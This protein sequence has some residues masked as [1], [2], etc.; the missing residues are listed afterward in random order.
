M[1]LWTFDTL[2]HAF[3]PHPQLDHKLLMQPFLYASDGRPTRI[4]HQADSIRHLRCMKSDDSSAVEATP[5]ETFVAGPMGTGRLNDWRDPDIPNRV[6]L[7]AA[8]WTVFARR[9]PE[10]AAVT[11]MNVVSKPELNG[12]TGKVIRAAADD[13]AAARIGVL[14]DG[15]GGPIRLKPNCVA[16]KQ[17]AD[18]ARPYSS[19]EALLKKHTT[20]DAADKEADL[21]ESTAISVRCSFFFGGVFCG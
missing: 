3:A 9:I 13:D 4:V 17:R 5:F 21:E 10:G 18:H 6:D 11:V 20:F 16:I 12:R 15:M 14:V 2:E 1:P 7:H 19:L 8:L